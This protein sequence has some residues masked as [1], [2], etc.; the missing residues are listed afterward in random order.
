MDGQTSFDLAAYYDEYPRIEDK[1]QSEL[2][3]S[4]H[5]RGP[6]LLFDLVRNL[7]LPARA[8]VVDV[9]CGEG[10]HTLRLAGE[11]GFEV[12]G[13]DPV[14]RHLQIANEA[15]ASSL[16]ESSDVGSRVSFV[17]GGAEAL[18]VEMASVDLVWCRDVLA[19]VSDLAR[20]YAEFHRVLHDEGR[21]LVYQM[22]GTTHLE[23]REAEWLFETMGVIPS[24][25]DPR[26]TETA[27]RSAGLQID[28]CV[29]LGP[30]WGEF[31]EE[32]RG[33]GSRQLL[34]AARL[35]RDPQRYVSQFG[36][37][38]YDIMFGDCLWHVYRMIGKLS[39]RIYLLSLG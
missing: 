34:H 10:Q 6:E 35:V 31:A 3:T 13:I 27:I 38:A 18:P 20:V 1:F 8:S 2:D 22:F 12:L 26:Q 24:S 23:P 28:E 25:A 32:S 39:P 16:A 7:G 9:G 21:V 36:Q 11:F 33:Q 17:S 19:H 29:D 30:E 37:G 4:L 5:P 15:L 14:E